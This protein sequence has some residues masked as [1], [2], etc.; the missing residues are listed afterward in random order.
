MPPLP[1]SKEAALL[2]RDLTTVPLWQI[3]SPSDEPDPIWPAE[4]SCRVPS[5]VLRLRL[6][7]RH[8]SQMIEWLH[9]HVESQ[10]L[11]SSEWRVKRRRDYLASKRRHARKLATDQGKGSLPITPEE[12]A[13]R[14][15]YARR[16]RERNRL[17][18]MDAKGQRLTRAQQQ[19]L[20]RHK[21]K[22]KAKRDRLARSR[23]RIVRAA[24]R[25]MINNRYVFTPK[26]SG[27]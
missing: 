22:L 16:Y 12:R 1:S 18:R 8:L 27:Q 20:A 13:S 4:M 7:E 21:A 6:P 17:A 11:A 23:N 9:R 15:L 19:I 3:V 2:P 25:D 10:R 26:A 5:E 24:V 14:A